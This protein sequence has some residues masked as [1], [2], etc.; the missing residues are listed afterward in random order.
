MPPPRREWR[1][2]STSND[3]ARPTQWL[4]IVDSASQKPPRLPDDLFKFGRC[5]T[6]TIHLHIPCSEHAK[7]ETWLAR[8]MPLP[9]RQLRTFHYT[10]DT[11]K[12][13][14]IRTD[15]DGSSQCETQLTT[16]LD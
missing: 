2:L 7:E 6:T 12:A 14:L 13:A 3:K 1:A 10:T 11:D 5:R 8:T 15:R 16:S 4:E 9:R